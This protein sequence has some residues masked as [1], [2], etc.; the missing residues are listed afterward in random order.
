M[1]LRRRCRVPPAATRQWPRRRPTAAAAAAASSAAEYERKI[2]EL[3]EARREAAGAKETV[4]HEVALMRSQLASAQA[5]GRRGGEGAACS[6]VGGRAGGER[7]DRVACCIAG[8]A[9]A[10]S[11]ARPAL[12]DAISVAQAAEEAR[13][14]LEAEQAQA[15]R[16]EVEL[17]E[18]RQQLGRMEELERELQKYRWGVG[19]G[20]ERRGCGRRGLRSGWCAGLRACVLEGWGSAPRPSP[21]PWHSAQGNARSVARPAGSA[22]RRRR[23]RASGATSLGSEQLAQQAQ[24]VPLRGMH[25]GGGA[26]PRPPLPASPLWHARFA[27]VH[28]HCAGIPFPSVLR[29]V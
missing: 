17:A 12:R 21:P 20:G 7:P 16:L 25:S 10:V 13:G 19:W 26:R 22:A 5:G 2:A 23:G 1:Q 8:A 18:A 11:R 15:M 24:R 4:A 6:A 29:S 9:G 14:A 3:E 27:L 28:R